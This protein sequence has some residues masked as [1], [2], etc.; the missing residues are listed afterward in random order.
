MFNQ[1]DYV[2]LLNLLNRSK[3]DGLEEAEVG[4]ALAYKIKA[5]LQEVQDAAFE[6]TVAKHLAKKELASDVS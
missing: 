5:K 6:E 4:V 1:H 2:N 3:F